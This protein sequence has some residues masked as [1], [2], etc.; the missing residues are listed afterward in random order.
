MSWSLMAFVGL[1]FLAAT[2]GGFF[3]PGDWFEQLKKPSWQP[4][5]W[6]FPVVWSLLYAINAFAGWLVWEQAGSEGAAF[7]PMV[8]Y[9]ISLAFNA[10]WSFVFFGMKRMGLATIEAGLL[11]LSVAVQILLFLPISQLAGLLL[12]PYLIWVTIAIALSASV[13]RLNP[14][15]RKT[16]LGAQ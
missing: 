7:W 8:A 4:P 15:Q 9:G 14:Q 11:W 3:K 6:A 13:W 16:A 12:I 10:G 2:S 5:N 1:N